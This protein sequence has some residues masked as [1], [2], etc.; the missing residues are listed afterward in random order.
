MGLRARGGAARRT[1]DTHTAAERRLATR[2][3]SAAY[4]GS[5]A[6]RPASPGGS[7]VGREGGAAPTTRRPVFPTW[8]RP[9]CSGPSGQ[10]TWR[11]PGHTDFGWS[12]VSAP[13]LAAGPP[14]VGARPGRA[15]PHGTDKAG[16]GRVPGLWSA[17]LYLAW[18]SP[19]GF[20]GGPG[21]T[22]VPGTTLQGGPGHQKARAAPGG[23]RWQGGAA[24]TCTRTCNSLLKRHPAPGS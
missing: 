6:W 22:C 15:P 8:P 18:P 5:A 9:Q 19:R 11:Q 4:R 23:D 2:R 12:G 20:R 14:P 17:A 7:G 24:C 13:A 3:D 10:R 21:C 1:G 16:G